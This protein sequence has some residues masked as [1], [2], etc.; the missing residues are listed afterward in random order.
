MCAR[1]ANGSGHNRSVIS[2]SQL[3]PLPA[4]RGGAGAGR[5]LPPQSCPR[6]L[7][8][9]VRPLTA[10]RGRGLRAESAGAL[11]AREARLERPGEVH[12]GKWRPRHLHGWLRPPVQDSRYGLPKLLPEPAHRCEDR[13]RVL[14]AGRGQD[15]RRAGQARHGATKSSLQRR[16]ELQAG[17]AVADLADCDLWRDMT[18]NAIDHVEQIPANPHRKGAISML[19][20]TGG[21]ALHRL[22]LAREM[23]RE[24]ERQIAVRLAS[25]RKEAREDRVGSLVDDP[26]K[27]QEMRGRDARPLQ[28]ARNKNVSGHRSLARLVGRM[29]DFHLERPLLSGH[30]SS[31]LTRSQ[32]SSKRELRILLIWLASCFGKVRV[33]RA[34]LPT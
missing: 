2:R 8:S 26:E 12:G 7:P 15:G 9:A 31:S 28:V 5:A 14:R 22:S 4:P 34:G 25:K 16:E 13:S 1:V 20:H 11:A 27:L 24:D 3:I 29:H 17:A 21:R 6:A 10:D 33:S 23:L 19:P 18:D 30:W 32:F